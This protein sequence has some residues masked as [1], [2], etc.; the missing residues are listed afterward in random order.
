M[1]EENK[2]NTPDQNPAA[3]ERRADTDSCGARP[4]DP[5]QD[6]PL[7]QCHKK[8]RALQIITVQPDELALAENRETDGGV[9]LTLKTPD[10]T[11]RIKEP[12]E[13]LKK[14]DPYPGGYYVVYEDGYKSF[15]PAEAFEDG[16]NLADE[17]GKAMVPDHEDVP[18]DYVLR[19]RVPFGSHKRGDT[20]RVSGMLSEKL[21]NYDTLTFK[22]SDLLNAGIV[23]IISLVAIEK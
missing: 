11:V 12:A 17:S 22:Y 8:V 21:Y 6:M 5:K 10:G 19:F 18:C 16:Y 15:S 3:D 7:F 2:I 1:E 20:N 13:Y 23:E 9:Y 14:N 4:F